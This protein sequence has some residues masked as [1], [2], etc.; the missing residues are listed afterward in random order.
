MRQ[1]SPIYLAH[2]QPGFETIAAA[3]VTGRLGNATISRTATVGN[4]NGMIWFSYPG[5]VHDLLKLRTLEDLFVVVAT[6]SDLSSTRAD[7]Q[8]LERNMMRSKGFE[9]ALR[10]FHQMHPRRRFGGKVPFRIIARQATRASYRRIDAQR[11]IEK[12]VAARTDYKWRFHETGALE[13]W[14]TILPG[15]AILA[16]RLSDEHMRHRE[17]KVTHLPA[18]LRPSV[19]AALAWLTAPQPDDV[20]L[21]PMC[22]AGTILIE[23]AHFQRYHL[24]LGGDSREEALEAA[25][26]NIGARYKPIEIRRWDARQLPLDAA[27]VSSAA[28]NLPFG[29]QLSTS[30]ENRALY[31]AFL[32][33]MARVLLPGSRLVAL[34]GDSRTFIASLGSRRQFTTQARY[35]VLVLGQAAT[36]FVL[37]RR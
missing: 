35:R 17:Y 2:T 14:L 8:M 31:P 16:L 10:L 21:D 18:S 11:A 9:P 6:V 33:E 19:A 37:K 5:P 24:L 29:R 1:I 13:L 22:G 7:L 23:R 36:V 34:T 25:R 20:F 27:S 3:E 4:K 30:E 26:A 32:S 15:E 28:V 12:G